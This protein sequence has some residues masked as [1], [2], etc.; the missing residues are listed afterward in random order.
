MHLLIRYDQIE[1]TPVLEIPGHLLLYPAR[2]RLTRLA[3]YAGAADVFLELWRADAG[4]I[5][6]V[7]DFPLLAIVEFRGIIQFLG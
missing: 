4:R 2:L 7:N 1:V 5:V 6:R 3:P